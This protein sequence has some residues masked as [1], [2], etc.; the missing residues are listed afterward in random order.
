MLQLPSTSSVWEAIGY[1]TDKPIVEGKEVVLYRTKE[2]SPELLKVDQNEIIDF[3][4]Y[5][6]AKEMSEELLKMLNEDLEDQQLLPKDIMIID[7][8]TYNYVSNCTMLN[9]I[10]SKLNA[11]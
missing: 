7:M 1:V 11:E 3:L 10:K 2:T 9:L 5:N 6:D 4:C 8:D